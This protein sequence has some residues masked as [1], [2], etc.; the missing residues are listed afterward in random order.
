MIYMS[1]WA[2]KFTLWADSYFT[3]YAV[4]V[5]KVLDEYKFDLE[6]NYKLDIFRIVLKIRGIMES[7]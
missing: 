2:L 1:N 7:Q 3:G 4:K 6:T 5:V